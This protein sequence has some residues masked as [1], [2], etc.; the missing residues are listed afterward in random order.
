MDFA[1]LHLPSQSVTKCNR[2]KLEGQEKI[3]EVDCAISNCYYG[4]NATQEI[5]TSAS[6]GSLATC[7]ACLA[8]LMAWENRSA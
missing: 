5:S 6:S 8:G 4:I 7:I 2:L 3:S 1:Q